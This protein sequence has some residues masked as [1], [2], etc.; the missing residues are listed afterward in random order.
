MTILLHT[1][2]N[3]CRYLQ[4]ALNY[5]YHLLG[6][7]SL[8]LK[9]LFRETDKNK[10]GKLS[11]EECAELISNHLNLKTSEEDLANIFKN[12]KIDKKGEKV[13][14]EIEFSYFYYSLLKDQALTKIFDSYS[15]SDKG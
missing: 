12:A 9:K 10:D 15:K 3:K 6:K 14:N 4:V 8:Y 13:F 1:E 2:A 7:Q 11:L 5:N